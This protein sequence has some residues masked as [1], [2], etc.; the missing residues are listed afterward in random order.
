MLTRSLVQDPDTPIYME[1]L[2]GHNISDVMCSEGKQ[3]DY[4]AVLLLG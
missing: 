4:K 1:A 3:E 2:S